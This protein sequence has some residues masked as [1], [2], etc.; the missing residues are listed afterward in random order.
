MLQKGKNDIFIRYSRVLNNTRGQI[1]LD[2]SSWLNSPNSK[3]LGS[4]D[5][6]YIRYRFKYQSHLSF[7]VTTEKDAGEAF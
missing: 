7:G 4:P 3:T 5:N 6:L 1:N 2:D